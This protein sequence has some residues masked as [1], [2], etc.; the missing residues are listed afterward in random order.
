MTSRIA[1]AATESAARPTVRRRSGEIATA[2]ASSAAASASDANAIHWVFSAIR[3]P[4]TS[5]LP[6]SSESATSR[7]SISFG[8]SRAK[9]GA[10]D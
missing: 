1:S 8:M 7:G 2:A 3:A 4:S 9:S 5:K 10:T 6:S